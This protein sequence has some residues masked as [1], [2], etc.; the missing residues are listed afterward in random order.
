MWL[1]FFLIFGFFAGTFAIPS[2]GAALDAAIS[3]R[4]KARVRAW[5]ARQTD[6]MRQAKFGGNKV[7]DRAFGPRIISRRALLCSI[8]LSIVSIAVGFSIAYFTSADE[9]RRQMFPVMDRV[10]TFNV[11]TVIMFFVFVVFGDFF[12]YAQTRI[13]FS[14]LDRIRNVYIS[15]ILYFADLVL[16][17][18]IF[19]ISYSLAKA[20]TTVDAITMFYQHQHMV[21]SRI[22]PEVV[23]QATNAWNIKESHIITRGLEQALVSYRENPS[24]N[25]AKE[26]YRQIINL[27]YAHPDKI[28]ESATPPSIY[29][30]NDFSI[31]SESKTHVYELLRDSENLANHAI[32][33]G[34]VN[35]T[36]GGQASFSNLL[37]AP[38][39]GD[40]CTIHVVER[41]SVI[42]LS[43]MTKE[44]TWGDFVIGSVAMTTHELET[45]IATKFSAL[46]YDDPVLQA[47]PLMQYALMASS[48]RP[49]G[50]GQARAS[51]S[52][53]LSL[54]AGNPGHVFIPFSIL[55]FSSLGANL[56]FAA[57]MLV[58]FVL[59]A[60][61]WFI[62]LP[63]IGQYVRKDAVFFKIAVSITI[64]V[65]AAVV[66]IFALEEI[67]KA[68]LWLVFQ[69]AW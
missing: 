25:N 9:I 32:G 50:I 47:L 2:L 42:S 51:D 63:Y 44:V 31:S 38:G 67:S 28:I 59:S 53:E 60:G 23:I 17:L 27:T 15:A 8:S 26:L 14:A 16:S 66:V 40:R 6:N 4:A 13:F 5:M 10:T 45:S 43:K 11:S 18:G 34:S 3:E 33:L 7:F 19:T 48:S 30:L 24:V 62:G 21:V 36:F 39:N 35:A 1:D 37:P 46:T 41:T 56:I 22:S 49:L 20:I 68:L 52:I 55:A 64:F 61:D 57:Y 54:P 69:R 65:I 29:C 12:S 58:G